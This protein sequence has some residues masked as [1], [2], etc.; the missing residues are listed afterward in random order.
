[1]GGE[2]S[3][4]CNTSQANL[5]EIDTAAN[6]IQWFPNLNSFVYAANVYGNMLYIGGDF[7]TINKKA[8]NSAA[9]FTL[10]D[11]SLTA[12]DPNLGHGVSKIL[13]YNNSIYLTGG[14]TLKGGVTKQNL[15]AIDLNTGKPLDWGPFP[16]GN[17]SSI[18]VANNTVFV[19]GSFTTIS[20]ADTANSAIFYRSYLAAIDAK[21]GNILDW[22]PYPNSSVN[23]L[24]IKD[25]LIY[26]GGSFTSLGVVT[27]SRNRLAAVNIANGNINSW[28]P[29]SNNTVNTLAI[30]GDNIYAG[31]SFTTVG[32]VSRNNIAAI[33]L[34]SGIT[35]S[36]NPNI[37]GS[38]SSVLDICINGSIV[39]VGGEFTKVGTEPR[40]NLAAL[41]TTGKLML[42]NPNPNSTVYAIAA[43]TNIYLGGNFTGINGVKRNLLACVDTSENS[44]LSDW[45]PNC[46]GVSSTSV[47]AMLIIGDTM[48]VGGSLEGILGKSWGG[49]AAISLGSK[50]SSGGITGLSPSISSTDD[51]II[52]YP[53][54]ASSQLNIR[55]TKKSNPYVI[56]IMN[57]QG[58]IVYQSSISNGNAIS[59]QNINTG[60]YIVQ[61]INQTE[62]ITKKIIIE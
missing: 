23:A 31:G 57:L 52:I 47:V 15:G 10:N 38:S 2:F 39:Y 4:I 58:E 8:R 33:D 28:N 25:S 36:W 32:G 18:A 49:F 61:L 5:A 29:N 7:N 51:T 43:D 40:N 56:K 30:V 48:Y 37:T 42:W 35:T 41:D 13:T 1:M 11:G 24:A 53:N 44:V 54:P 20:P 19:G 14:F 9:A 45:N 60:L 3:T 17:I 12:W 22:D 59:V 46:K 26:I 21:T 16:S 62:I 27:Q 50:P 6:L 55:S 34:T